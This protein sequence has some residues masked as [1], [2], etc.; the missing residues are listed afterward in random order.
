[1]KRLSNYSPIVIVISLFAA[2]PTHAGQAADPHAGMQ[3]MSMQGQHMGELDINS[4]SLEELRQLPGINDATA[5]KIVEN[6]PYVRG[7]EL[8]TK[9]IL[10]KAAF[11]GLKGHIAAKPGAAAKPGSK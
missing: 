8:I 6:R 4:A 3:G 1:M 2:S 11:D 7:D 9:K 10:S 5:K